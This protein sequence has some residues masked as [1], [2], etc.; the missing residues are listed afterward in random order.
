MKK[1]LFTQLLLLVTLV[2][3]FAQT[4]VTLTSSKDNTIYESPTGILSS[5]AGG[6]VVTGRTNTTS[7]GLLRR[8]LMQFDVSSIPS[9]ATI[10][11][12]SLK[13]QMTK[14]SSGSQT[15]GL[16]KVTADWGEGASDAGTGNGSGSGV[17]AMAGDATWIH[18]FS[19]GSS[20]TTAGGDFNGTASATL[21]VNGLGSYTWASTAGLV[22][23]VQSWVTSGATNFGWAIVGNESVFQTTKHF[24]TKE[25]T[26]AAFRPELSITYTM[27]V[28]T[29]ALILSGIYDGPVSSQPKG[30][31]FYVKQNI[32]DL[33]IFGVGAANNGGGTDGIEFTFPAVAATAGQFIYL[34]TDTAAF[35]AFFGFGAD[36][37][38]GN[39]PNINGDDAV[40]LF[41]NGVVIDLYG[42][43]NQDGTGT[44]WDYV[45][46]WVY[47]NCSKGPNPIFNVSDWTIAAI[48]MFDNQITNA[49]SPTPMP[50]GTYN[51]VCSAP[52][53]V[54]NDDVVAVPYNTPTT[55]SPLAND[56]IPS[57]LTNVYVVTNPTKGTI[58]SNPLTGQSTY[59]PTMNTCGVDM[60][61]YGICDANGCDT[62][63]VTF[64]VACPIPTYNI[65]LVN[66]T[67][68]NG[69]ADSLT[70][71]CEVRGLVY[72]VD[73][74]GNTGLSFTLIDATGGIGVFNSNDVDAYVVTEG[75]SIHLIGT[76]GQY[77]GLTQIVPTSIVLIS[78]GNAIKMPTV[79]TTLG[80]ATESQLVRLNGLTLVSGWNASGSF[81]VIV[82]DGTNNFTVRVDSDVNVSGTAAPV[83]TFD[84][85]GIGGQ[86]DGSNP[87]TDGYQLFPRDTS[88]IILAPLLVPTVEFAA[89]AATV[90]ENAGTVTVDV[91]IA[92]PTM[93]ATTVDVMLDM[94][95][96]TATNGA[97]FSYTSPTTLTFPANSTTTQSVTVTITDDATIESNE[98]IILNLMNA[99]TG[100]TIG[101]T[102]TH[103][104]TINDNDAA[105]PN[106]IIN[107][108]H[109][110][111]PS[112]DSL[113]YIELYNNSGSVANLQGWYFTQGVDYT[114]PAITLAAGDYLVLALDSVAMQ[115]AY[116]ITAYQW[117]S[118]S[119]SNSGEDVVI[120]TASGIEVDSVEYDDGGVWSTL[121]DGFGYG[122]E[123]CDPNTDN[124]D[125]A[126]W[127]IGAT[128]LNVSIS[129]T[130]MFGTPGAANVCYVAPA[131][132]HPVRSVAEM[133]NVDVNGVADSLNQGCE[134]RGVVYGIDYDGDAGLSF[135]MIG[136]GHGI[137]VFNFNDVNNYAVNEGDSIHVKGLIAQYNGL[138]E[139]IADSVIVVGTET[140]N[141]PTIV[142]MLDETTESQFIKLETVTLVDAAQWTGAGSGFNVDVRNTTDT[143]TVRIDNDCD[144]FLTTAPVGWF[145]VTG[146][147]GQ[148]DNSNPY[149]SGYQLF[150]RNQGDIE[151]I[152]NTN[153]PKNLSGQIKLFPNPTNGFLNIVSEVKLTAVRITNVLG[154]EVMNMNN[155]NTQTSL[156]VSHLTNGVYIITFM[157]AE[158][159]WSEQFVKN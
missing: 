149:T 137:N 63:T 66:T 100:V 6:E 61:T 42:D 76:I 84:I 74:D 65:G 46:T 53:L 80:E 123:L 11:S 58:T 36:Y 23:D 71:V 73:M 145:N 85:I 125:P 140:I 153:E 31:E 69:V 141:A 110:N 103:T 52:V 135:T 34:S 152:I 48:N 82:T 133:T 114:F 41:E 13:L 64:N 121:A 122:L 51:P 16:H 43:I 99:T 107:E 129:G 47:R 142:T 3:G 113:E 150:P 8:A 90:N 148:F 38:N 40:E 132:P 10:T 126:N 19:P 138:L 139:I 29:N 60:V 127:N 86:F 146:L 157:T 109:Y 94:T 24:V 72:G 67:D 96:S 17:T 104:I 59:T 12:V 117:T 15:V 92:N 54:A 144:L 158:G 30:Y 9:N 108:I 156:N 35:R 93:M 89:A 119:L 124:L 70:T 26:N 68:A 57:P 4:T 1:I 97:D 39:A 7:N 5:G 136:A 134:L 28:P 22:A 154:Q 106:V 78:Q 130:P 20:W 102:A 128:S 95:N 98:T 27:P 116:G 32:P 159:I 79:V 2:W 83:G 45:D 111:Q 120:R 33:S 143:F 87:Y 155:V 49:T 50:V 77:N 37:E 55:Y 21:S 118:G 44:A 151:L 18:T 25:G 75:D 105:I 88:D 14:T 131:N 147:G 91:T 115:N 81:N 101:G 56:I 112:V 62:A